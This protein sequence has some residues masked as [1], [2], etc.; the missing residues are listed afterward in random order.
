MAPIQQ[1][2]QIPELNK[3]TRLAMANRDLLE[4]LEYLFVLERGE[5]KMKAFDDADADVVKK[6]LLYSA[7]V[8]Y[9]RPFGRNAG[10]GIATDRIDI[11]AC[12]GVD[13]VL[14]QKLF[15]LRDKAIAHADADKVPVQFLD[16]SHDGMMI[17]AWPKS[18]LLAGIEP[19][20][21]AKQVNILLEQIQAKMHE[22]SD[23]LRAIPGALGPKVDITLHEEGNEATTE[24]QRNGEQP[25]QDDSGKAANGLTGT[26]DSY[27]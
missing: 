22:Y 2:N 19:K 21:L 12:S 11:S 8:A 7:I 15:G 23:K 17:V 13:L 1:N 27:R 3:A 20:A 14:H 25:N 18:D 16:H 5:E 10:A 26:P 6:S 24:A 4:A 9:C